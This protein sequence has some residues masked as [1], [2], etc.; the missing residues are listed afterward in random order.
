M[1]VGDIHWVDLPGR[2]G[3]AQAGRRPAI[4][5]QTPEASSALPTVLLIPFTTQLEALRFPGTLL[6]EPDQENGLKRPSVALVF[7]LAAIDRRFIGH[8][9]GETSPQVVA[10]IW[11]CLIELTGGRSA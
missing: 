2:G 3:H 5:F 6:V 11:E 8:R 1:R 7:Q 4:V 9:A 10:Q